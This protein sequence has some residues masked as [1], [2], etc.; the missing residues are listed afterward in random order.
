M[1]LNFIS[2]LPIEDITMKE[3]N[4]FFNFEVNIRCTFDASL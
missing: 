3:N 1:L 2:L 4:S